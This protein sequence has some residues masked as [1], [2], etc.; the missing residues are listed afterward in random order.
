VASAGQK[1]LLLAI[2]VGTGSVRAALV[3]LRGRTVA[4]RARE[5]DQ[6]VPALAGQSSV[7]LTGGRVQSPA[8]AACWMRWTA[9]R[10]GCSRSRLAARCTAQCCSMRRANSCLTP[11]SCGTT[12]A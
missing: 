1:D 9:P 7:P 2:D 11:S 10:T 4:F 6:I 12:S 5:H 3:D 8:S